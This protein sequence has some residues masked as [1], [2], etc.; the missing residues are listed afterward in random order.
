[1]LDLERVFDYCLLMFI[2]CRA[3]FYVKAT[4]GHNIRK[5]PA[6]TAEF[7]CRLMCIDILRFDPFQV[8]PRLVVVR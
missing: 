8:M 7:A 2:P 4:D 5:C 6:H 1:M 3:G